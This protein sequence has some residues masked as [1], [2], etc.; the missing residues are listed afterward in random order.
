MRARASLLKFIMT[1]M[2]GPLAAVLLLVAPAASATDSTSQEASRA[3][4]APSDGRLC[5]CAVIKTSKAGEQALNTVWRAFI[6]G[7][8]N[9]CGAR[10][11]DN[12]SAPGCVLHVFT[13]S[14]TSG[15]CVE[16]KLL[17]RGAGIFSEE[18]RDRASFVATKCAELVPKALHPLSPQ[19]VEEAPRAQ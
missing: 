14:S 12:P 1:G 15:V 2:V 4:E 17:N 13:M 18:P 9:Y 6:Q 16:H 5:L 3:V 8:S 11:D 19:W 7:D 10:P